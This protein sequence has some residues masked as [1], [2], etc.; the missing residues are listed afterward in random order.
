MAFMFDKRLH[1]VRIGDDHGGA[2][3]GEADLAHAD[4]EDHAGLPFRLEAVVDDAGEG[5]AVG[6]VDDERDAVRVASAWRLSNSFC[7]R[8]LPVGF[9]GQRNAH[10]GDVWRDAQAVEIDV[11]FDLMRRGFDDARQAGGELAFVSA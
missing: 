5:M 6:V 11:V 2:H 4:A 9:V 10:G 8:T 7:V 1:D 3:A